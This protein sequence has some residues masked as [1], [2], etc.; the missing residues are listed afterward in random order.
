[1]IYEP[2]SLSRYLVKPVQDPQAVQGWAL[3]T[4]PEIE[5]PGYVVFGPYQTFPAGDYQAHFRL[6]VSDRIRGPLFAWTS[7]P[8]AGK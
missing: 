3:L 5:H 2:L 6:K 7:R 1:M 4:D 8:S